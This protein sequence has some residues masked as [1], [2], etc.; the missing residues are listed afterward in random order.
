MAT[1]PEP[2]TAERPPGSAFGAL[3]R[4][5]RLAAGLTQEEL[6]ERAGIGLRS[7]GDME[8]GV[9]HAPRKDT[10]ALLAEALALAPA[11]RAAFAEAARRLRRF[12]STAV[13]PATTPGPTAPDPGAQPAQPQVPGAPDR[14]PRPHGE[15]ENRVLTVL[16]AELAG[17][18]E[19]TAGLRPEDAV[20]LIDQVL[21]TMVE[22]I[23]R[24]G[25]RI[26][27]LLGEG[28][29]AF[30]G[31][32]QAHENE[33]ERA[34]LAALDLRAAVQ[35]LGFMV[36][37]GINAG[38]VYLGAIGPEQQREVTV[39]GPVVTVAARLRE[40]AQPGQIL[41]GAT[42]YRH[43][44]GTF[45][46][47]T[48]RVE[49]TGF[50]QPIP[51]YEVV[52]PLLHPEKV[53]GIEG[54]RAR[55]IGRDDEIGKLREALAV[56]RAGQGHI[57][58]LI[59]DAGVG[60]SRLIAELKERAPAPAVGQPIPLWLEGRC[61]DIGVAAG[62]WP[63]LDVLRTYFAFSPDDDDRAR[64]ER[65]AAGVRVLVAQGDLTPARAEELLPYLGRLL[66]ARFGMDLDERVPAAGPEQV[67]HQTF[68]TLRDFFLA[69]ARRRPVVLILED[70]HWA[71]SL[72]LDL[73]TL[74][75]ETLAHAPLLLVCA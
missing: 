10:V 30:F 59:G 36:T 73:L 7:I 50:S 62:Y 72:S 66:A 33:S 1:L 53:R 67:K 32:P 40:M 31:T 13:L 55:L 63:F 41:V 21:T 68:L 39:Q 5:H 23:E 2:P 8:R 24:Y 61:L 3:L 26:N 35:Q 6:A 14:P 47:T 28:L 34:I 16:F 15:G 60:K 27:R 4:R 58:T 19:R 29:L 17:S 57:A 65:I 25:G 9:P 18:V 49:A 43:T 69:L 52:R 74:L 48:R 46:F 56:V 42:V 12:P 44:R 38:E 37:A 54:L 70:L 75:L 45:A 22:S 20:A 64:G 11:D 71:D 51:A